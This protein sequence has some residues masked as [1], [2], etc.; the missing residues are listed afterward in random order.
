MGKISNI[1]TFECAGSF[2]NYYLQIIVITL[3]QVYCHFRAL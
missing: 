2:H 1:S 3:W